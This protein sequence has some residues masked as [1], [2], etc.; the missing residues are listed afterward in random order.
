MGSG[1]L[2][3]ARIGGHAVKKIGIPETLDALL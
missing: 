2:Y 3:M 1:C